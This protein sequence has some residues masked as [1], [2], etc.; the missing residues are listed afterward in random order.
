METK[1]EAPCPSKRNFSH[2]QGST[3][4]IFQMTQVISIKLYMEALSF[5]VREKHYLSN[6]TGKHYFKI[7]NNM[8]RNSIFIN[9]NNRIQL[10]PCIL[11]IS[12]AF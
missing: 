9:A 1:H 4:V 3:N 6:N 2:V 8:K 10:S 5:K 11:A 12:I 7:I